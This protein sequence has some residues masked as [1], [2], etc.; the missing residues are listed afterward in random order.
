MSDYQGPLEDALVR[1]LAKAVVRVG[2]DNET[3]QVVR[4]SFVDA[5][6][7]VLAGSAHPLWRENLG[8][9]P[10]WEAALGAP[11]PASCRVWG[12]PDAVVSPVTATVLNGSRLRCY[13]Y[14][15]LYFGPSRGVHPSDVIPV[16]TANA[17][18]IGASGQ[19]LL[20]S[21][22]VA[23]HIQALL[24]D[25]FLAPSKMWD[26][27]TLTGIGAV[28]G[29]ARLHGLDEIQLQHAIAIMISMGVPP[30]E[31]ESGA[32]NRAGLLTGWKRFNAAWAAVK[33]HEAISL[34]KLGVE[35]PYHPMLGRRSGLTTILGMRSDEVSALMSRLG[36]VD[37]WTAPT[38]AYKRWPAGSRAQASIKATLEAL[39]E[40]RRDGREPVRVIVD[41]PMEV[42]DHMVRMD[43]YDPLSID[44][45]DHSLPFLV[46][47]AVVDGDVGVGSFDETK[48]SRP[49]VAKVLRKVVSIEPSM[50]L[51]AEE[52]P[53]YGA[54]TTIMWSDGSTTRAESRNLP[55]HGQAAFSDRE[56]EEK[57]RGLAASQGHQD[58]FDAVVPKIW[59]LA[60]V[61]DVSALLTPVRG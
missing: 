11:A 36:S 34:V 26:Y 2:S 58:W 10:V 60:D 27:T 59:Q 22:E 61:P 54:I 4:R 38:V 39:R 25:H 55:G 5:I 35:G 48:R 31:M 17:E 13:D 37:E 7:V 1:A 23:F 52:G 19:R 46:A 15:D 41:V 28:C 8:R 50:S 14:N 21:A 42:H 24:G 3:A 33:A 44:G 56:L 57:A 32:R 40:G 30:S 47:T 12:L 6:G 20:E 9:W 18:S 43:A 53:D 51:T 49:E 45:A 29:L 16:L